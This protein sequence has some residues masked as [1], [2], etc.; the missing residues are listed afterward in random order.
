[1]N[2]LANPAIFNWT[3]IG[4]FIAASIRWAVAGNLPQAGYWLAAAFL[5]VCVTLGTK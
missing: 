3:I 5:N 4:M 1:M 2:I